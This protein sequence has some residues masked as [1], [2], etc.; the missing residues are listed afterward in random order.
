[1]MVEAEATEH[2]IDLIA[3]GAA[4][5]DRGGRSRAGSRPPS[6]PSVS[7]AG[8]SSVLAAIAAKA[9]GEFPIFL[10]YQDDVYSAVEASVRGE[11]TDALKIAAKQERESELSA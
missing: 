8:P 4:G 11:L 9:T 5:A 1:M 10:D 3:G 2:T 6:R 7:C